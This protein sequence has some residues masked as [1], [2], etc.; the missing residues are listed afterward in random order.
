MKHGAYWNSNSH[1][2]IFF[3]KDEEVTLE[4]FNKRLVR[5]TDTVAKDL[6]WFMQGFNARKALNEGQRTVERLDELQK[7]AMLPLCP[8][9]R[10]LIGDPI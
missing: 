2:T 1:E 8:A 7:V 6:D 5:M 3:W 10:K 9:C 4:D